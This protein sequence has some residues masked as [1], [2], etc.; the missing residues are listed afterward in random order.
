MTRYAVRPVAILSLGALLLGLFAASTSA[1]MPENLARKAKAWANSEHNSQYLVQFAIDGK[2]P[3]AG[4]TSADLGAAWCVHKAKSGDQ[5]E[6]RLQW[7]KPVELAELIYWGRTTW[8]VNECWKDYEVYLDDAKTPIVTGTFRMVHGPQRVKIPKD[9]VTKVTMKFLNSYGG[10]NPGALEIQA[11]GRSLTRAEFAQIAAQG[12]GSVAGMP[13]LEKPDPKQVRALIDQLAAIHGASYAQATEHRAR[14]ERLE[15]ALAGTGGEGDTRAD[16][17][18]DQVEAD[19]VQLQ[20]DVLLFDVDKAVVIR[21]HEIDAT[22]VYT[23]HYEGFLAGGGLYAVSLKDPKAEPQL[24]VESPTGQILDC[25]LAYD[26]AKVL[27]SWRQKQD[28][29]YHLWTINTDGSGLKQLTA[30][31]WHDYNACWLPDGGIA[32]LSTRNPQFAYCWHA[33]VGILHRINPDGSGLRRISANYLNDFTPVVLDDGRLIYSRWEYVDRPAIPIQSL[34][35]INPD[36]TG[37][38]GYFGNRVISPATFMEA[39]SIPGSTKIICTMTGHNGPARGAIGVID[40]SKGVNAQ[41]AIQNITPDVPVPKVS[42]GCGNFEGAKPYSCPYPLDSVRFLVSARGPVLVRTLSGECQSVALPAPA[43][44]MQ[45]FSVQP[46]RPRFR[47]PVIPSVLPEQ[48]DDYATLFVQDIY[49]GLEPYVERGE[50]KTIRVVREM[51]KSVRID[52]SLRA[53]GFQFPVISCGA[54]YAG[55]IVLGDVPVEPNGSACFRVP[56]RTPIYFIAL[57]SQGRAVQRMRSFTHLMPGEVQ[58]C[59]GCHEH[60]LQASRPGKM[61]TGSE[62]MYAHGGPMLSGEVPVPIFSAPPK[63]LQVPEWG[64]GGFDYSRIVQPV[65]DQHCVKCHNPIDAPK[66]IDLTGGKTDFFSVSYECLARENQG[67]R[68]SPYVNWIPSYNGQEWN[69]LETRPKTW[70]SPASKLAEVILSGHPDKDGKPQV[71]MDETSRRRILSWMDLNV[72]YYG[73]SET[74]YPERPGCRQIFP[75][76]LKKVLTDV[77]SRRCFECHKEV[78]TSPRDWLWREWVRI[79]EPELNPFLVAPL[80]KSAGGSERCGKPIFQSKQDPDYQA[81]LATFKPV[82]AMLKRRPRMDMPGAQPAA[83]VC[84]TCQ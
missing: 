43:S 32:F 18:L 54:T 39:R 75:D 29:G 84:R 36:G 52:P 22:H 45:Y 34:W 12:Q 16:E 14:L 58:G 48:S 81:I 66:R 41:E 20:R 70:G 80:A 10:F 11:F 50:V 79:T 15:K 8:F 9:Q 74:A 61:G 19:L 38:I 83:D 59:V 3:A 65:L 37:L 55:K 7:D 71:Q 25:D 28:E 46:L 57:D 2:I 72:P 60:R 69:I 40:R 30:G 44:G 4:S 73:T 6:F 21:R 49:N 56:A 47:P 1:A 26:G 77:A 13:S 33:P 35:T 82:D 78:K 17:A 67:G 53:F 24:L 62:P 51:P 68:G 27:F 23:Y 5:A 42:E 76:N 63:D 64:I 31:P